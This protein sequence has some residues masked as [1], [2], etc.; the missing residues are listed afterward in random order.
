MSLK[1]LIVDD[2][3]HTRSLLKNIIVDLDLTLDVY[4]DGHN[5]KSGLKA[6]QT[7]D[8]D[9]V[10]L[11][12]QMPDGTGF[13]FLELVPDR[14]FELLFITAHQEYAIRAIKTAALDYILKPVDQ[15]E[16]DK[17]LKSAIQ[18]CKESPRREINQPFEGDKIILKT[19]ESVYMVQYD[20][21]VRCESYKNY[22]TFFL[23]NGLK[24]TVSKTLKEYSQL[25]NNSSFFKCHRSH[26]INWNYFESFKKQN[27][28]LI[29]MKN[30]DEV[31]LARSCKEEFFDT[32]ER[33]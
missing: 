3:E 33:L 16:L 25:L 26:I 32:L 19:Q 20:S 30:G 27:G 29:K 12:V 8:P 10:I 17:A 4:T 15:D 24:I 13:D 7:V 23:E 1:V 14:K 2:E 6:V 31:P 21:L 22:T 9:I 28:G 18:K 5:L 11:D